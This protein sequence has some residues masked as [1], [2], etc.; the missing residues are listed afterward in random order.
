M[1]MKNEILNELSKDD[2]KND[3]VK[4]RYIYLLVCNTFSYD[5]RFIYT[6]NQELKNKIYNK[7]ISI[8]NVEEYEIVCYSFAKVLVDALSLYGFDAEIIR[9]TDKMF[10]HVYVIVKC[11]GNILKLDPTKRHDNTRVKLQSNTLDFVSISDDKTFSDKLKEADNIINHNIKD[12][13]DTNV[14]Y[15]D[16][17]LTEFINVIENSAN[18]RN[19]NE[20]Q[21]FFEKFDYIMALINTRNDLKRYDDI[22]YYYSYLIRKFKLNNP[23]EKY[24]KPAIFF[25][26]DDK[27]MKDIINI[28]LIEYKK[29]PPRFFSIRKSGE[30]YQMKELEKEETLEL[31]S[32]YNCPIIQYYFENKAFK[33]SNEQISRIHK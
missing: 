19:I 20:T 5:M 16:K 23:Q 10:S 1:N 32:E 11:N 18:Q 25:K 26:N 2:Y 28:T 6:N 24:I 13:L 27:S 7:N 29:F 31:L 15:N 4:I 12:K 30:N 21:L 3:F 14:Y 8:D 22:D 17:K 33:M 9:E